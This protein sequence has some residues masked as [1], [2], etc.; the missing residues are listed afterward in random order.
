MVVSG[1]SLAAQIRRWC[2]HAQATGTALRVTIRFFLGDGRLRMV[3]LSLVPILADPGATV[4][5][6]LYRRDGAGRQ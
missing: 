6:P 1:P 5:T 4:R 2:E 3:D